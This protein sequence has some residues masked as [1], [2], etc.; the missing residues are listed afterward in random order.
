MRG[1]RRRPGAITLSTNAMVLEALLF[2]TR[3]KPLIDSENPGSRQFFRQQLAD[4]FRVPQRCLPFTAP[5][6]EE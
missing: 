3:M 1:V 4:P 6:A 2:K 5:L